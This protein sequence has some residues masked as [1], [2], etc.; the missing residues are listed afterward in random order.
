MQNILKKAKA[1]EKMNIHVCKQIAWPMRVLL[2]NKCENKNWI[3]YL[4]ENV[5]EQ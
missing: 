2:R 3:M 5:C 1:S 4:S